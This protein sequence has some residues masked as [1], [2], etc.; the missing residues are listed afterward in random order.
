MITI[1]GCNFGLGNRPVIKKR[2]LRITRQ[3][4]TIMHAIRQVNCH[5]TA[6]EVYE[7]VRR[8]LPRISLGTVYRNLESLSQAGMIQ[9]LEFG[10]LQ[11]RFDGETKQHYHVRCLTCGRIE[12][13]PGD[14]LKPSKIAEESVQDEAGYEIVGHRLEFLGWCPQCKGSEVR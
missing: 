14:T 3:R 11:K 9:K 1:T 8:S 13:L 2:R 12:D 6:S 7:I 10:G 5:P 4:Q